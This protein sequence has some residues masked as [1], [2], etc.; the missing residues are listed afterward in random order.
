MIIDAQGTVLRVDD[1]TE[2]TPDVVV[3]ETRTFSGLKSEREERDRTTLASTFREKRLNIPDLGD[4]TVG[5]L[6]DRA[7]AGQQVLETAFA[8]NSLKTFS[9]TF[10]DNP[11]SVATF[12]GYVKSTPGTDGDVDQDVTGDVVIML[13]S[14]AVWT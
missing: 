2:G 8:S 6:V 1:S 3:G 10:T 7:D 5:L 13:A 11:A 12:T 4:L 14:A 9:L